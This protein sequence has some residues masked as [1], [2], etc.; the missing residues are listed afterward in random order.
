MKQEGKNMIYSPTSGVCS[1]W[2]SMS[3]VINQSFTEKKNIAQQIVVTKF[4]KKLKK[5]Q[6]E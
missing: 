6:A 2:P 1:Q 3:L 5:D 4:K